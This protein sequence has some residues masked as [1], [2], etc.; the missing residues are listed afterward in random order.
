MMN[1]IVDKKN[2]LIIRICVYLILS[3]LFLLFFGDNSTPLTKY[4][5]GA[6][7]SLF[8][9]FGRGIK[10]GY[11]PYRD[12][13]DH[14]GPALFF[15]EYLGQIICE[16]K[17]GIFI[18]QVLNL[19]LTFVL[20]DK[21]FELANNKIN[22]QNRVLLQLP[23]FLFLAGT[24][25]GGNTCEEFTLPLSIFALY[26]TLIFLKRHD[27]Y[28]NPLIGFVYGLFFGFIA[29]DRLNNALFLCGCALTI[30][31]VLAIGKKYKNII[32][33]ALACL[34]GTIIVSAIFIIKYLQ[35]DVLEEMLYSSFLFA[36][37]YSIK[38]QS[39]VNYFTFDHLTY[40]LPI[41]IS[42]CVS[43]KIYQ[44]NPNYLYLSIITSVVAF[45]ATCVGM[46]FNHYFIL[47]IPNYV[48]GI[49]LTIENWDDIKPNIYK[50]KI[51][52]ILIILVMLLGQAKNAG[53]FFAST[54]IHAL[55]YN[56]TY[57]EKGYYKHFTED[58]KEIISVIPENEKD[59]IW[60]YGVGSKFYMR[61]GLFPCI[62]IYDYL[63]VYE[64]DNI[65]SAITKI[66]EE[67]VNNPPKW[68]VLPTREVKV[69]NYIKDTLDLNY[70]LYSQNDFFYLY[71]YKKQS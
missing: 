28:F 58:T 10:Y 8:M 18:Y 50:N 41:L 22:I 37:E 14:K 60:G 51:I 19:T 66:S 39:L 16:G 59:S 26:T 35:Y 7:S 67:L 2:K 13:F 24:L 23:L 34:L 5:Y 32:Q 71:H 40:I 56:I 54:M 30:V 11:I 36:F 70:D 47:C 38:G 45:V 17:T 1:T 27:Y 55:D 12:L 6:D 25:E 63:D 69:P 3:F 42:V 31:I 68:M 4:Y 61:T 64:V 46:G 49:Y 33:N 9:L 62:S 57:K 29:F 15:I 44:K 21:I 48:L 53:Y 43:C 65:G 20:I 52:I